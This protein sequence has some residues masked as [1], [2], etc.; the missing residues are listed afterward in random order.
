MVKLLPLQ[1]GYYFH[2]LKDTLPTEALTKITINNQQWKQDI[3]TLGFLLK[4]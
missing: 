1:S 4:R 3:T 2:K